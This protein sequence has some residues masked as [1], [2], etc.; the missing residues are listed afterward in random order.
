MDVALRALDSSWPS[1]SF[2]KCKVINKSDYSARGER[3]AEGISSA[4]TNLFSITFFSKKCDW[5]E[6][7]S[8]QCSAMLKRGSLLK[9]VDRVTDDFTFKSHQVVLKS[10]DYTMIKKC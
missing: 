8:L 1:A 5:V 2:V 7:L 6:L 4:P 3:N 10:L 9:G